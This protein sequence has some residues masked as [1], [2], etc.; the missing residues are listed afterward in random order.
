MHLFS[1]GQDDAHIT[2]T[3]FD[4]AT[5]HELLQHFSPLFHQYTTHAASGSNT[6]QLPALNNLSCNG[7]VLSFGVDKDL[8]IIRC[9]T[10]KFLD[11]CI[12]HQKSGF[13]FQSE[14]CC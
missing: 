10:G 7:F 8:W 11:D 5:F 4:Y 2:M 14:F 12:Q 6:M 9:S 13:I 3:G 1:A